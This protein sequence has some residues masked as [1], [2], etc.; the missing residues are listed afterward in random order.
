MVLKN[1]TEYIF[2]FDRKGGLLFRVPG[3]VFSNQNSLAV[4]DFDVNQLQEFLDN[5]IGPRPMQIVPMFSNTLASTVLAIPVP[6]ASVPVPS[7]IVCP[8]IFFDRQDEL[9]SCGRRALNNMI[10]TLRFVK[11]GSNSKTLLQYTSDPRSVPDQVSTLD[12]CKQ[13]ETR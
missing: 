1:G 10:G 4:T 7:S 12:L 2:S 11:Q 6:L 5:E 13:F 8:S 3:F 9:Q